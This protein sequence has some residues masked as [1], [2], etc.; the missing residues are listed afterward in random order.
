LLR[1]FCPRTWQQIDHSKSGARFY[2][3]EVQVGGRGLELFFGKPERTGVYTQ[4]MVE[5]TSDRKE[6]LIARGLRPLARLLPTGGLKRN[7]RPGSMK[8]K[9]HVGPDF[10]KP[11]R[12]GGI[13]R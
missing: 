9:P 8:G 6:V 11:L 4:A 10:F 1:F 13:I 7:R 2:W 5:R 3:P 12:P